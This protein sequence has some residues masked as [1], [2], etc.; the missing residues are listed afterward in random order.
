MDSKRIRDNF[1]LFYFKRKHS[2]YKFY[3]NQI[4]KEFN[5]NYTHTVIKLK[6]KIFNDLL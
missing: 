5:N 4:I 1:N 6:F 2:R 3:L